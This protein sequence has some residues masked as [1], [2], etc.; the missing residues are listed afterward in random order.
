VIDTVIS[1]CESQFG[2]TP[3]K[4]FIRKIPLTRR[5]YGKDG[6][7]RI[8]HFYGYIFRRY[9]PAILAR[10]SPSGQCAFIGVDFYDLHQLS[11]T[12]K[13]SAIVKMLPKVIERWQTM[14][15]YEDNRTPRTTHLQSVDWRR[16]VNR[17]VLS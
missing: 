7:L 16:R 14:L 15:D 11:N 10:A 5:I 8:V 13:K 3:C 9:E 17:T 6:I 4:Q 12:L 1:A 2:F